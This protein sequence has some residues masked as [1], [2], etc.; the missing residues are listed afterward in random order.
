MEKFPITLS[1]YADL[2]AELKHIKTVERPAI[3]QAIAEARALGDLS[4]N[5]EYAAAREKQSHIET[6]IEKLEN[7]IAKADIIDVSKLSGST[8]KFGAYITIIDDEDDKEYKYQIVGE[9]E[10]DL[11]KGKI[12]VVSPIAR[13]L[14]GKSIGDVVEVVTPKG[15]KSYEILKIDY[16]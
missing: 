16:K 6:R 7:M 10:A 9:Y 13:A 11:A 14:I 2:E 15:T 4:E 1:G 12:S 8:I 3:A 5:A